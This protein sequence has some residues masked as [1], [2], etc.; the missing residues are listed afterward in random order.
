MSPPLNINHTR[1]VAPTPTSLLQRCFCPCLALSL[2]LWSASRVFSFCSLFSL[3]TISLSSFSSV[4]FGFPTQKL[5]KIIISPQLQN[6]NA[7]GEPCELTTRCGTVFAEKPKVTKCECGSRG[8]TVLIVQFH[9]L[10]WAHQSPPNQHRANTSAF[11]LIGRC[12][13]EKNQPR[14]QVSL[15]LIVLLSQAAV[16]PSAAC[17][18]SCLSLVEAS[19]T[20]PHELSGFKSAGLREPPSLVYPIVGQT[21]PLR[22]FL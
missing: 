22:T 9:H 17:C 10:T 7:R 1:T 19:T 2:L 21:V 4:S 20:S 15:S 11:H 6:H 18:I 8:F 5:T 12:H 13:H 3:F 14:S 16:S